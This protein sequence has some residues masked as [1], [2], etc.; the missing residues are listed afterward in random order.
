MEDFFM[1]VICIICIVFVGIGL[2]SVCDYFPNSQ[3]VRTDTC[4]VCGV[5]KDKTCTYRERIDTKGSKTVTSYV[6]CEDC[7]IDFSKKNK[8]T[9]PVEDKKDERRETDQTE[10]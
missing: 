10:R 2:Y 8:K 1:T 9:E 3:P 7:I 4:C 6:M 5:K